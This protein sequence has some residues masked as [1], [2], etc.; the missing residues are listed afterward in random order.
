MT[1]QVTLSLNH[2]GTRQQHLVELLELWNDTLRVLEDRGWH[3]SFQFHKVDEAKAELKAA[4]KQL[5]F[6]IGVSDG[7]NEDF[8]RREIN[9]GAVEIG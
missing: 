5:Q 2:E 3:P 6:V 8:Y 1:G 4:V 7:Y 9:C